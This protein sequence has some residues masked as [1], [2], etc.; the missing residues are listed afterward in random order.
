MDA[1]DQMSGMEPAM[2]SP[3]RAMDPEAGMDGLSP[4]DGGSPGGMGE[5][6][7][8]SP[9]KV[10]M[11]GMDGQ[12]YQEEGLAGQA[13]GEATGKEEVLDFAS[14]ARKSHFSLFLLDSFLSLALLGLVP[15][16]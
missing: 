13:S 5:G 8:G 10:D 3:Q 9:A 12:D 11:D 14:D 1:D 6:D 7:G 16:V 4:G 2:E 15:G